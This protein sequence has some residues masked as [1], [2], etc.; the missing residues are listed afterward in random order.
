MVTTSVAVSLIVYGAVTDAEVCMK[1]VNYPDIQISK[2]FMSF[3]TV[4]FAY[5]GHG[6]CKFFG[7]S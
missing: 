4:M 5:G 1:H 3:G 7:L 6:A 2:F